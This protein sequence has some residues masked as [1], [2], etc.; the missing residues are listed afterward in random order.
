MGEGKIPTAEQKTHC[1]I[2]CVGFSKLY[3][4]ID[5]VRVDERA[6]NVFFL[7][8][9]ENVIEIYPGGKW[10]YVNRQYRLNRSIKSS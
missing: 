2:V 4:P 6:G 8:G 5:V 7:A 9:E 3:L 1:F 10:R